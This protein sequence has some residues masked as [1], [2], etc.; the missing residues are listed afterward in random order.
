VSKNHPPVEPVGDPATVRAPAGASPTP[1]PASGGLAKG[2]SLGRY[3]V[4]DPLGAGAMGMVYTAYDPELDRKLA[5]KIL[6]TGSGPDAS[7][8]GEQT[9]LLREAQAMARLQHPNILVVHDVGTYEDGVFVAMELVDGSTLT[10]WLKSEPRSWRVA[11]EVF[12]EA[13]R[14]L[15]AA[16]AA[17]LV[18]RDFKP[19]NVLVDH[20]RRV[21]VA[22]F[23]LAR[24]SS[25]PNDV[26]ESDPVVRDAH[27]ASGRLVEKLTVT[28]AMVGTP[29]Y[30]S[31]EQFLG[32]PA[33]AESDQFSFCVALY[34]ALYRERP[35]PGETMATIRR[36]VLDGNMREPPRD[37]RVP[38][39]LRRVVLRG[40]EAQPEHR[41]PSMDALIAELLR[42][43]AQV[44]RRWLIAAS[45]AVGIAAVGL[46]VR[47][48]RRQQGQACRGAERKL[49]GVWD[50]QRKDAVQAA[51]VATG[52]PYAED[53]FR[54][55]ARALDGFANAWVGMHTEA[56]EATRVRGEQSEEALDLRMQCLSQRREEAKAL[57][58]LF[59]RA[60]AQVVQKAVQASSTLGD[61]EPCANVAALKA[62]VR[63][64]S[65]PAVRAQ[66]EALRM[67]LAS[68]KALYEA[69][70]YEQALPLVR[71]IV[72]EA[73]A[74]GYP[75]VEAEAVLQLAMTQTEVGQYAEAEALLVEAATAAVAG[76]D[77]AVAADAWSQLVYVSGYLRA[78]FVDGERW[79][80]FA[81]AI[82]ARSGTDAQRAT[83][84]NDQASLLSAKGLHE[85]AL[86]YQRRAL[87]IRERLFGPDNPKVAQ[88]LDNLGAEL[89][90]LGHSEEAV[91]V[92]Q[93]AL[94]IDEKAY[95]TEHP[96]VALD[97]TNLASVLADLGK[98]DEAISNARRALVVQEKTLGREH[99][100]VA[101]TLVVLGDALA[102]QERYDEALP[103][104]RR[105][106][107]LYEK[108]LGPEH[109]TV[110]DALTALGRATLGAHDPVGARQLLERALTLR[111]RGPVPPRPLA[112]TR[113]ALARALWEKQADRARA[114]KLAFLA[115]DGLVALGPGGRRQLAEVE[116]WLATVTATPPP[117]R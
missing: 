108:T 5:L 44:R 10:E 115:R 113:L 105:S 107:A 86:P 13:G 2:D 47:T 7:T 52:Q 87:E 65:D 61:L 40:L 33:T 16:H 74:L 49:A 51:F 67:R 35:Y 36:S 69:A 57:V 111:D 88:C 4:L 15:A 17:G 12:V 3:I 90:Y 103:L 25:A 27:H 92:D 64:P 6:R 54:G 71:A 8:G 11:L 26:V 85:Q 79:G 75:P 93:R 114:L 76:R 56:C 48:V 21:R 32:R 112:E 94:A 42:D 22:D 95:G 91:R 110:A 50:P 106:V 55:V 59:G 53:A 30:M 45:A 98:I 34:Q 68:V 23:G 99:P 97:L 28:G 84:F 82:L 39:W 70:R 9:M 80:K 77:E 18:H 96:E 100:D 14:G 102:A 20:H 109:P 29:A 101:L 60:D 63:P 31:P 117:R 19:D 62:P 83:L 104:I 24:A 37:S 89:Y 66:V 58:D 81:E 41:W 116:A 46:S 73:H 38:Q 1:S 43:P 72:G 78:H